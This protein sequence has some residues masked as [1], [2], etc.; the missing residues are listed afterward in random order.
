MTRESS[1]ISVGMR[2][3]RALFTESV[4]GTTTYW[5]CRLCPYLYYE[6]ADTEGWPLSI[7]GLFLLVKHLKGHTSQ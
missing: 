6:V 1:A 7:N 5:A 2:P 3:V 4:Q